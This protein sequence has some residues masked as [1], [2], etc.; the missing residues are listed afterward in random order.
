M[1]IPGTKHQ[2][3]LEKNVEAI[4]ISLSLA[5]IKKLDEAIPPGKIAGHRYSEQQMK[6]VDR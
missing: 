2:K 5:D 4:N 6:F 3:F 1:P